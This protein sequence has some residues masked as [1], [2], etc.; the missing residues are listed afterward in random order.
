LYCIRLVKVLQSVVIVTM[1]LNKILC[2][3]DEVFRLD[4]GIWEI[5]E[6]VVQ[7]LGEIGENFDTGK[8]IFSCI[9]LYKIGDYLIADDE[10]LNCKFKALTACEIAEVPDVLLIPQD[11][12]IKQLNATEKLIHVLSHKLDP[13]PIPG[14]IRAKGRLWL[15]VEWLQ[16]TLGRKDVLQLL[17]QEQIALFVNTSRATVNRKLNQYRELGLQIQSKGGIKSH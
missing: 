7:R 2:Q 17:S 6:G 5:K 3:K 10:W 13:D 1:S 14:E 9:S 16:Y 12:L 4:S 8:P 11:A 15:F